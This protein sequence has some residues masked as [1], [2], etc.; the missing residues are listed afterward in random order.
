MQSYFYNFTPKK[1]LASSTLSKQ[2]NAAYLV[3]RVEDLVGLYLFTLA[4]TSRL[5]ILIIFTHIPYI[6]IISL[7]PEDAERRASS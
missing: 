6:I 5:A 4:L 1:L 7:F 3:A 2:K